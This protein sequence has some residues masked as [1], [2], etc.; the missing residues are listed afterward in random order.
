MFDLVS[1]IRSRPA[2]AAPDSANSERQIDR[3]LHFRRPSK[4]PFCVCVHVCTHVFKV[5]AMRISVPKPMR[6]KVVPEE[7]RRINNHT[8]PSATY[9]CT[10]LQCTRNRTT[11]RARGCVSMCLYVVH[12]ASWYGL[13]PSV[14]SVSTVCS[15]QVIGTT[16]ELID[17]VLPC[18]CRL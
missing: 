17:Y 14:P 12:C 2:P 9:T 13:Q 5:G 7:S 6:Q 10:W 15:S 8:C 11:C 4:N 1:A 16:H 3:I 18:I